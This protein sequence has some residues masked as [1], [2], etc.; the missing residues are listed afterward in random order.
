M[1]RASSAQRLRLWLLRRCHQ[2]E[3]AKMQTSFPRLAKE[4]RGDWVSEW[5]P[6]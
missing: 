3:P 2:A 4:A 6:C 1:K 5:L